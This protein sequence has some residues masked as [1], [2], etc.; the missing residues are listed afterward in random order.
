MGT[1]KKH[2][3]NEDVCWAMAALEG[4]FRFY[5]N[6]MALKEDLW[7]MVKVALTNEADETSAHERDKMIYL[8]EKLSEL[9]EAAYI[10]HLQE[11]EKVKG[12][13]RKSKCESK[14]Q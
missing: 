5:G 11:K 13:S 6:E 8:Y 14:K 1:K 12:K 10:L 9:A 4:F 3:I 7:W 2:T